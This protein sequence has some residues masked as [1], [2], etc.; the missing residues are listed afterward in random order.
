[1]GNWYMVNIS[2]STKSLSERL[3]KGIEGLYS[4]F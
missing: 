2:L 1:M 4:G 3:L